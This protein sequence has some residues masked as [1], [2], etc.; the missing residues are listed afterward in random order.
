MIKDE[1]AELDVTRIKSDGGYNQ[2]KRVGEF[3]LGNA[4]RQG[5]TIVIYRPGTISGHSK[6][7]CCNDGDYMNRL[8][9]SILAEKVFPK[10]QLAIHLDLTPV[11]YVSSAI[12]YLSL[13]KNRK[14]QVYHLTQMYIKFG[15]LLNHFKAIG[16]ELEEIPFLEWK[17]SIEENDKH[18]LFPLLHYFKGGFLANF[19]STFSFLIIFLDIKMILFKL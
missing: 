9:R 19:P 18:L 13:K 5:L 16:H 10:N 7:G 6:T 4:R 12:V 1:L 2:S 14:S 15:D 11:D 3:I 17:K 8:M